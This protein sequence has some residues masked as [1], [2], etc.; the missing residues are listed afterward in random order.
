MIVQMVE[1]EIE[2]VSGCGCSCNCV[3]SSTPDCEHGVHPVGVAANILDCAE[4]CISVE[5]YLCR[6]TQASL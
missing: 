2:T 3:C 1:F 6:C 5:G 4:V